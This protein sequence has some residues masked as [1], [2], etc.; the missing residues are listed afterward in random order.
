MPAFAMSTHE[1]DFVLSIAMTLVIQLRYHTVEFLP[2][3][4]M[5]LAAW[6]RRVCSVDETKID[7][8]LGYVSNIP[9][10]IEVMIIF[11][12]SQKC[13]HSW[14]PGPAGNTQALLNT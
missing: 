13:W 9:L 7:S 14:N 5:T 8:S 2:L 3:S 10:A 12:R 6:V 11:S 1:E 4:Q